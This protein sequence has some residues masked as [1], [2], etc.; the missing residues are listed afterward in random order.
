MNDDPARTRF[1]VIGL[2]R[3]SGVALAF[4]GIVIMTDRLVEPAEI[5]GGAFIAIGAID[6]LIFPLILARRWRTPP[7]P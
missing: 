3:L 7:K 5:V 4:L 2:V 6:V 1:L